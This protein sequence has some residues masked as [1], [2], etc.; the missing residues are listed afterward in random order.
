VFLLYGVVW[1]AS[2]RERPP[3]QQTVVGGS[4]V[5]PPP[6]FTPRLLLVKAQAAA[7]LAQTCHDLHEFQT[8]ASWSPTY[9]NEA[10]APECPLA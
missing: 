5:K 4:A 2:A 7:T 10:R 3:E 6:P 1:Q 9:F 8:M